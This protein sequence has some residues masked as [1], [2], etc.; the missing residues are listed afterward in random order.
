MG[1]NACLSI[2]FEEVRAYILREHPR[3]RPAI[4]TTVS[5]RAY[6][7]CDEGGRTQLGLLAGSRTRL[8]SPP[9]RGDYKGR[10]VSPGVTKLRR[11]NV[12]GLPFCYAQDLPSGSHPTVALRSIDLV[13]TARLA[14][15]RGYP[16]A[17]IVPDQWS[18]QNDGSGGIEQNCT[19][20]QS[21]S[22]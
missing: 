4:H 8:T 20:H 7:H 18:F 13:P 11:F 15:I 19:C 2:R 21:Q 3:D 1:Q 5:T 17:G 6:G 12:G 10:R 22:T 14:T 9:R 16:E